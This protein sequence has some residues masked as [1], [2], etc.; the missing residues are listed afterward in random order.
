MQFLAFGIPT[1]IAWYALENY[2][3]DL[4]IIS[5]AVFLVSYTYISIVM[6][7]SYI[8]GRLA[9]IYPS[10]D[11]KTVHWANLY[12]YLPVTMVIF[13]FFLCFKRSGEEDIPFAF[14][15]PKSF[16]LVLLSFIVLGYGS[17][18]LKPEFSIAPSDGRSWILDPAAMYVA[19]MGNEARA[20]FSLR[21]ELKR[22]DGNLLE[23][24]R[25]SDILKSSSSTGQVLMIAVI[26]QDAFDKKKR[27]PADLSEQEKKLQ[28][29]LNL[30]EGILGVSENQVT[31]MSL[32]L[33]PQKINPANYF[34]APYGVELALLDAF[35][36]QLMM[37]FNSKIS[38]KMEKLL[39]VGEKLMSVYE[40]KNR[41]HF[42]DRLE[43][44]KLRYSRSNISTF[45]QAVSKSKILGWIN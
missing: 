15:R 19:K 10:L 44:V 35:E 32:L 17:L 37:T 40:G 30:L 12:I 20:A 38:L 14:Q 33:N 7:G 25:S 26:A 34:I 23:L 13:Y 1:T 11:L 43:K 18:M 8:E 42:Q 45:N 24:M 29:L 22:T 5:I 27:A 21:D 31:E 4:Y 6:C 9:D 41:E 2:D 39:K 28:A 3:F 16:L 36:F